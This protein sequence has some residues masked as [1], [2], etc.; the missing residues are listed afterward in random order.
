MGRS[1]R[2]EVKRR[3]LAENILGGMRTKMVVFSDNGLCMPSQAIHQ[4]VHG[5]CEQC[6][7]S[8]IFN[9]PSANPPSDTPHTW[10]DPD[11]Q[12]KSL[13]T[14]RGPNS[15]QAIRHQAHNMLLVLKPMIASSSMIASYSSSEAKR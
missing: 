5:V 7:A 1:Q 2:L 4:V 6:P 3:I 14:L 13:F 10:A 12:P 15:V 8:E 11:A 9:N